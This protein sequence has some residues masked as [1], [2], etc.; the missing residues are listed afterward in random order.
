[1]SNARKMRITKQLSALGFFF[2]VEIASTVAHK[3]EYIN[4]PDCRTNY[5]NKNKNFRLFFGPCNNNTHKIY[6]YL[7]CSVAYIQGIPNNIYT[8]KI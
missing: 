1:M 6:S 4:S 3:M 8:N 7:K 2:F 5:E